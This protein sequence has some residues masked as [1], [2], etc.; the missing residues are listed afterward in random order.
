MPKR[1][2]PFEILGLPGRS[3]AE[4][5]VD[6]A[7]AASVAADDATKDALADAVRAVTLHPRD[8]AYHCFWEPD[9]TAYR[10]ATLEAFCKKH[11]HART[12]RKQLNEAARRLVDEDCCPE[13]LLERFLCRG[14]PDEVIARLVADVAPDGDCGVSLEPWEV[15]T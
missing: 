1:P 9:V 6:R 2:N 13:R 3:S 4:A 12:V 7:N 15:F 11:L 5:V 14:D 10:D 8:R